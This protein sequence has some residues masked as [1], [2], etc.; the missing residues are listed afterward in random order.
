MIDVYC[1]GWIDCYF[2]YLFANRSA[3][4]GGGLLRVLIVDVRLRCV[5]AGAYL[6]PSTEVNAGDAPGAGQASYVIVATTHARTHT[7]R[8]MFFVLSSFTCCTSSVPCGSWERCSLLQFLGRPASRITCHHPSQP[9]R[10][11]VCQGVQQPPARC[12]GCPVVRLHAPALVRGAQPPVPPHQPV[13]AGPSAP[14]AAGAGWVR[15]HRGAQPG[16]REGGALLWWYHGRHTLHGGAQCGH[17]APRATDR[18]P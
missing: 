5:Q 14:A 12:R 16:H 2:I 1:P 15:C 11:G 3:L 13:V 18:V 10:R 17:H 9:R 6:K 7:H 4:C 8:H